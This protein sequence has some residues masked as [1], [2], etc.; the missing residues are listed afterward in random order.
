MNDEGYGQLVG[1]VNFSI[2][3]KVQMHPAHKKNE[4]ACNPTEMNLL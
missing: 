2:S 3:G 1:Q 4:N